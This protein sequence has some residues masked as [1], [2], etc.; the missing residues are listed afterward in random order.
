MAKLKHAWNLYSSLPVLVTRAEQVLETDSL[1]GGSFHETKEV[2]RL[3]TD[4]ELKSE[5]F[6]A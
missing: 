1:L 6:S 3:L 2:T 4:D 5:N